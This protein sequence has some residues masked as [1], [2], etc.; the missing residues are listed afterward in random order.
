MAIKSH[1][2]HAQLMLVK[3]AWRNIWRNKVRS[4]VVI[5]ALVLGLW[6]G[7]FVSAF[8]NGMMQQKIATI[9]DY[10]MSHFQIHQKGFRDEFLV[11][12][13]IPDGMV[14]RDVLLQEPEV[15]QVTARTV[16]MAMVST[17]GASGGIKVTGIEPQIESEVTGLHNRIREGTYFKTEM[18]SPVLI[19][20]EF[21]GKYKIG[22]KS[23][24][25]LTFQDVEGEIVAASF[26]VCGIYETGNKMYDAAHVFVKMET[27]QKLTGIGYG[28]HEI[29]VRLNDHAGAENMAKMYQKKYPQLEVLSWM[30]LST[31]MRY[32]I[33][34]MEVYTVMIVGIILLAMLFSIINTMLMAVLERV[35]ELG[36]LMAIGMNRLNIFLMILFETVFLSLVGG[37]VGIVLSWTSI[38]YFG[39]KGINLG[40]AAY[41]D[42]GYS[43][44]IYPVIDPVEYLKVA[45]MVILMA[46]LASMYP[47]RK[48]LNFKPVDALR[49]I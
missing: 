33:E 47:A 44:L 37:P 20:S 41:G 46:L 3:M 36:M 43:N 17:A 40:D 10:E 21:A 31:G 35:R 28:V 42:L 24:L 8:V 45:A 22:L 30:D 19:S 1:A 7:I 26:R 12:Q 48:A 29:A 49:K 5:T 13:F 14:I 4:L 38:R 11:K 25:V 32:M 2:S 16:T 9:I 34:A 23:K 18:R 15:R 6:A 27:M 39:F